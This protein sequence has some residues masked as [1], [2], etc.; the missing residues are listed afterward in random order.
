MAVVR[1]GKEART[2]YKVVKRFDGHTHIRLKL[3]TGRTHQ[4]RVHMASIK[5]PIVGDDTY[6]GRFRIHKGVSDQLRDTLQQL[7]RQALHARALGLVH[8]A[9]GEYVSWETELP[10]DMQNLLAA[11]KEG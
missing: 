5:Y 6:G 3:E 4:I 1:D 10:D 7:E 8:P 2:H 11:L 9:S